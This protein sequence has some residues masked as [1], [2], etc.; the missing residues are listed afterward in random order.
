MFRELKMYVLTQIKYI[1]LSLLLF[2]EEHVDAEH[3]VYKSGLAA[4]YIYMKNYVNNIEK[5]L[6]ETIDKS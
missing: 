6:S 5:R 1:A 3:P 2:Y 4:E